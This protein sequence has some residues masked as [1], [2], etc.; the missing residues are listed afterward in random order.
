MKVY[1]GFKRVKGSVLWGITVYSEKG[2]V[3]LHDFKR[4]QEA[5]TLN[6]VN[7]LKYGVN[8]LQVAYHAD[9]IPKEE[10]ILLF[11]NGKNIYKWFEAGDAPKPYTV[12]F[13]DL[14]FEMAF[15]HNPTEVIY[16]EGANKKLVFKKS[17][18]GETM[19]AVDFLNSLA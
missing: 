5:K 18:E 11:I 8:K 2:Q 19:K 16:S 7:A 9:K 10:K 1:I 15:L 14:L 4:G 17:S 3:L 13:S 6:L 12:E